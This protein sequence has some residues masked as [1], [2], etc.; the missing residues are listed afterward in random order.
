M[1]HCYMHIRLAYNM[2]VGCERQLHR[3][4]CGVRAERAKPWRTIL[5]TACVS[6]CILLP[7]VGSWPTHH[8]RQAQLLG[9][10][11]HR[12][13][14]PGGPLQAGCLRVLD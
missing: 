3:L 12:Q 9:A 5:M 13:V 8:A 7:D 2:Q 10:G 4:T 1:Q 6:A 14:S 11:L